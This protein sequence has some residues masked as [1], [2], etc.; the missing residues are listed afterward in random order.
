TSMYENVN[1][2]MNSIE[3]LHT[4]S[5]VHA[6]EINPADLYDP[7]SRIKNDIRGQVFR[8]VINHL[9][10]ETDIISVL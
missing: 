9:P 5:D 2:I 7:V 8:K 6:K 4:K 3:L 1:T 10:I